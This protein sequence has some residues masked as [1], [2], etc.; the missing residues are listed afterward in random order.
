MKKS[1]FFMMIIAAALPLA[2][3]EFFV[4]APWG[5]DYGQA[6][7]FILPDGNMRGP[8]SL[9]ATDQGTLFVLDTYNDGRVFAYTS[10]GKLAGQIE[11]L[12]PGPGYMDIEVEGET[13]LY[14]LNP[15]QRQ[16]N[17]ID[18][19]AE[20]QELISL[21]VLGATGEIVRLEKDL[22][23]NAFIRE[24][25]GPGILLNPSSDKPPLSMVTEELD[26]PTTLWLA[27]WGTKL[28]F[29][30]LA[31]DPIRDIRFLRMLPKGLFFTELL[32][33]KNGTAERRVTAYSPKGWKQKMFVMKQSSEKFDC[34]KWT[35][36]LFG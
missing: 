4:V 30:I 9:C 31:T 10:D 16:V 22:R 27:W 23:G 5:K 8:Q 19:E 35:C 32:V 3:Q 26:D 14:L 20:T 24:S 33:E 13:T 1:V 6:S 21:D 17:R 18:L 15:G 2:A 12:H 34:Q 36:V 7:R 29:R 11:N 25:T 28:G